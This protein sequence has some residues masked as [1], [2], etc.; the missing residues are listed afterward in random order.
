MLA[1]D[2]WSINYLLETDPTDHKTS[3]CLKFLECSLQADEKMNTDT[4]TSK[5]NNVFILKSRELLDH[6]KPLYEKAHS[7]NL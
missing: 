5:M 7:V 4:I 2:L 6:Y 3:E 1:S